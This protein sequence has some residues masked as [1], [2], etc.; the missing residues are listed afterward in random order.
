M[1]SV[2]QELN[3][4]NILDACE[5]VVGE[6][7]SPLLLQRNSYINRVYELERYASR[8]R[9][10]AK[11]YRPGRWPGALIR[12][13]HQLLKTLAG[14]EI[15]VIPPLEI[16]GET[17][18]DNIIP[19][20][21]FPKRG[22]RALDEFNQPTWEELGRLLARIHLISSLQTES[23]RVVWRPAVATRH[24]LKVLLNSPFLLPAFKPALEK[25]AEE[26]IKIKDP[27]FANFEFILCHGDC[28]KGNL[29]HRPNEGIYIVDFDDICVAPPV[30]DLWLLLPDEP[31]MCEKELGWFLKG[32]EL[33]R[34]FDRASLDLYLP[35]RG[36]RI[37]HFAAWLAVQ[38]QEPDFPLHF[39]E[40]GTPRYW[41]ELI[42]ELQALIYPD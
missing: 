24:H 35:L 9:L 39:P 34:P 19:F 29:I 17:L 26:F 8:E 6:K 42:K 38:S 36:M 30:Q 25:T 20:A 10:I 28:H 32:Y 13:E 33:F 27:L 5:R 3:H 40:T 21:L 37:L 14:K 41:N 16:K 12:E 7:L 18:F 4:D 23:Q 22:G 1:S 2:W 31:E 15:P 11:F